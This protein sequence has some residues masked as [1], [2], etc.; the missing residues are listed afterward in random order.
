MKNSDMPAML[1]PLGAETTDGCHG[2]TKRE[3]MAM[4]IFS[5]MMSNNAYVGDVKFAVGL[6]DALLAELERTCQKS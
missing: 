4:H 5:G 3:I 2:L 1:L 6:A